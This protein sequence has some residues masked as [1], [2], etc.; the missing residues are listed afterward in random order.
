MTIPN[1]GS[2][3]TYVNIQKAF[4]KVLM[5]FAALFIFQANAQ[6]CDDYFELTFGAKLKDSQFWVSPPKPFVAKL[7]AT[8]RAESGGLA[9][10]ATMRRASDDF[11]IIE[12]VLE[13][14]ARGTDVALV[15]VESPRGSSKSFSGTTVDQIGNSW[16][17]SLRPIC[18]EAT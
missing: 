14:P 6:A 5:L 18:S 3:W 7:P 11:I 15:Q 2:G 10:E 4:C 17:V 1:T 16:S 12:F 13:S 9:I 8:L